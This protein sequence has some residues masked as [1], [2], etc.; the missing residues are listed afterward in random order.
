MKFKHLSTLLFAALIGS[1][2]AFA[3]GSMKVTMTDAN[4]SKD[5][6]LSTDLKMTFDTSEGNMFVNYGP[7]GK[8]RFS[9]KGIK[10][11]TFSTDPSGV[12]EITDM[13]Q[14]VSL[15]RNPVESVL[16]FCGKPTHPCT[17]YVYN[18]QGSLVLQANNW[19][20][21]EIYVNSLAPGMYIVHYSNNSIKFIKK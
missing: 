6:S 10:S 2:V 15:L 3:R 7:G 21:H 17:L 12:E 19:Q 9:L 4:K 20:G 5:F 1:S 16:Q 14:T 18:M 11:I 8:E 13:E